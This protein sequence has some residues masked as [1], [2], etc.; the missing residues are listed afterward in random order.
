MNIKRPYIEQVIRAGAGAL[1][2]VC[3]WVIAVSDD[4]RGIAIGVLLVAGLNLLQSGFTGYC[5]ME[6]LLKRLG[7]RGE[8]DTIRQLNRAMAVRE[9][10]AKRH[11]D[12]LDM[13]NEA[14][15]EIT[16]ERILTQASRP[17]RG[18]IGD[19]ADTGLIGQ[20]IDRIVAEEDRAGVRELLAEVAAG[21]EGIA[22]SR[23]R[24]HP[25]SGQDL[26]VEGRFTLLRE[27]GTATGIRGILSD[28]TEPHLQEQ[29]IARM[30]L[31]DAL[32][33]LPNRVLLED[34]MHQ[35]R[36]QA[37]RENQRYAV[38]F[39]DLDN[40]KQVNDIHGHKKGD[41]LLQEVSKALSARLRQ[42]DTLARWGGDEFVVLLH[43]I[44][45]EAG[46]VEIAHQ[47]AEEL[48]AHLARKHPDYNVTLSIGGAVYPD[49]ADSAE[50][51]LIHADKALFHVKTHGRNGVRMYG[52]LPR[53]AVPPQP[54]AGLGA[55]LAEAVRRGRIQVHYQLMVDARTHQPAGMEA[56]ARW[57]DEK[58][59]WVSPAVFVP[60][61]ENLGLIE[62]LGLQVME[63]ALSHFGRCGPCL[64]GEMFL[65][66]NISGRQLLSGDLAASLGAMADRHGVP[67]ERITL[68][69]AESAALPEIDRIPEQL[70]NL[71]AAGFR[72]ALD[73][74]G[75][76]PAAFDM[77]HA[78]PMHEIKLSM[79]L[80]RR[81]LDPRG[82]VMLKGLIDMGRGL[83]MKVV[84]K[85]I[86]DRDLADRLEHMGVHLMQG[87]F[88]GPALA[89]DSCLRGALPAAW[90][91]PEMPR[92]IA[93]LWRWGRF[94]QERT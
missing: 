37:D 2:A 44:E 25:G 49:D 56:L 14:V 78:T 71:A 79:P 7:F 94:A 55:R 18:L 10:E 70:D 62:S 13:L 68:E 64:A 5:I 59:G 20:S 9:A 34:R 93:R 15:I 84:A 83:D 32:T 77:L 50:S 54:Q 17:L 63:Q 29:R 51:L 57:H 88:F 76:G 16:P 12:T 42:S 22:R 73:D 61:A 23:F 75:G 87:Y 46:V 81:G 21:R 85:G 24:L 72:L 28:V 66:L 69:I 53:D 74:F 38:L 1:I 4:Y 90:A 52:A 47:L 80:V 86:E 8:I 39:V 48:R 91:R 43:H 67:R 65:S 11:M 82:R 30:A 40:F 45:N 41:L 6:R 58:F 89:E 27:N 92:F 33:G 26:W 3:A 36:L 60:L 31:H 19:L 35:A